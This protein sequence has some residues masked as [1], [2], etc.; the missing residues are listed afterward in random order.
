M[1]DLIPRASIVVTLVCLPSLAHS[2]TLVVFAA[3]GLHVISIEGRRFSALY[4]DCVACSLQPDVLGLVVS[5]ESQANRE[6]VSTLA[7]R[8]IAVL[9]GSVRLHVGW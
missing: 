9:F 7:S 3:C 8:S 5:G 4:L 6:G 1:N 2:C